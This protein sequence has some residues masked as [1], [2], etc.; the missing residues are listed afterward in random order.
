MPGKQ[1]NPRR[2]LSVTDL[3]EGKLVKVDDQ[4]LESALADP[5]DRDLSG[6]S[7][8]SALNAY[9]TYHGSSNDRIRIWMAAST[10][11]GLPVSCWKAI[12]DICEER[13]IGITMHCAEAPK[14]LEIFRQTY[15]CSPVEFCVKANLVGGNKHAVLAHMVNLDLDF[16]LPLLRSTGATV[17]HNPASNCKL[18]SGIA[19]VP[20]M[21]K[22][23]VKV[24]LGT[25]G[26]PCNNT[27]D[28]FR[29]MH[30]TGLIHKWDARDA[31]V[32]NADDVLEMATLAGATALGL[33]KDIGSLEVGKKA[34]FV[35]VNPGG[36][37]CAPFEA[38][39]CLR[40]GLDPVTTLVYSCSGADV[41]L[42]VVDGQLLVQDGKLTMC[43]ER[44]LVREAR[45]VV[46]RIRTSSGIH[47]KHRR[48]WV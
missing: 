30:L 26:A 5:R 9:D 31:A 33:E 35:V 21:L 13:G 6:M 11:R 42:V 28:L 22:G 39:Q 18:G 12:G 1:S 36:L 2:H 10:P 43:D 44:Q 25:D 38:E 46:E 4:N 3:L 16:D 40:G 24:S 32:V 15:S 37:H 14:D 23:G 41:E 45:A 48:N 34:D 20:E 27:Y 47:A 8:S 29:E 7:I 19:K 17:A